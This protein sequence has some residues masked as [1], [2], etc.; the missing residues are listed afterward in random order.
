MHDLRAFLE[1]AE[2]RGHLL[3]IARPVNPDT[4][5]GALIVELERRGKV[6]LFEHVTGREGRLAA[7]LLGRRDLLAEVLG[8][9]VDDV[10]PTYLERLNCRVPVA[11]FDGKPPVQ[12][13]VCTGSDADLRR[14]PIIVHATKD[15][16]A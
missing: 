15:A 12:E 4:E 8:V 2:D 3:R 10:V 11:S 9:A 16:G 14:L 7:N 6:G 5:A 1:L 13:V